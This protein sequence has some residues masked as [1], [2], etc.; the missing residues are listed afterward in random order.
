MG[1][2]TIAVVKK[3][4]NGVEKPYAKK[5]IVK[6]TMHATRMMASRRKLQLEREKK[7]SLWGK[8]LCM[9]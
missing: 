7:E 6:K 9:L 4:S 5:E 8:K 3:E 1:S 2:R